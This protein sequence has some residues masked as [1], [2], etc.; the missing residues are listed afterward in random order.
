MLCQSTITPWCSQLI[1]IFFC[2]C[3][4]LARIF[5]PG[6]FYYING[7]FYPKSDGHGAPTSADYLPYLFS[8]AAFFSAKCTKCEM[9]AK[10]QISHS[11]ALAFVTRHL[12][13]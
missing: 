8:S 5:V 3:I 4:K 1:Y 12:I 7:C 6:P 11:N 9:C 10:M 13:G 2:T